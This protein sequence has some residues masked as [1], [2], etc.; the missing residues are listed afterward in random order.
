MH[1]AFRLSIVLI[2]ILSMGAAAKAE[3]R[4]SAGDS[5]AQIQSWIA[6]LDSNNYQQREQATANLVDAGLAAIDEIAGAAASDSFEVSWRAADILQRIGLNGDE[7]TLATVVQ[8][9]QKLNDAG[10]KSLGKSRDDLFARWKQVR[11]DRAAARISELGGS[12]QRF[13]GGFV[14]GGFGGA[15]FVDLGGAFPVIEFGGD[16]GFGVVEDFFEPADKV[17]LPSIDE[18]VKA[19]TVEKVV[20]DDAVFEG[21]KPALPIEIKPLEV[22]GL[23]DAIAEEVELVVPKVELEVDGIKM[24]EVGDVIVDFDFAIP[25][26][27]LPDGV[28]LWS[29]EAHPG[30]DACNVLLSPNWQGK[31]E[32]FALLAQLNNAVNLTLDHLKVPDDAFQHF[33]GIPQL[34]HVSLNACEYNRDLL[35]QFKRTHP[36]VNI[37]AYGETLLGVSG[38][39]HERGFHVTHV[40]PGSGAAQAGVRMGD[41]IVGADGVALKS[42]EDLMIIVSPKKVDDKLPLELLRAGR[43]VQTVAILTSRQQIESAAAKEEAVRADEPTIDLKPLV[44]PPA[45]DDK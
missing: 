29:D 36:K 42:I 11:H 17:E 24:V 1:K 10:V 27:M 23:D 15:G 44:D 43:S 41:V 20:I 13:H 3:D 33:G 45:N 40:V 34:R 5:V 19:L 18:R 8:V 9:M 12:V 35:L 21:A 7:A 2:V 25:P 14:D 4:T 37:H 28:F 30:A 39:P 31:A 26:P 6:Q 38:E 16:V 32:D 22:R